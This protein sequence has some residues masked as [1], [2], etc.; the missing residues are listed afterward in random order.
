MGVG[1]R[2]GGAELILPL[3]IGAAIGASRAETPQGYMERLYANYRDPSINPLAHPARYFAAPLVAAFK[4]DARLARG[5]VGYLDGDPIC[6]CQDPDGLR[7]SV[8]KVARPSAGKADVSVSIAFPGDEPRVARFSLVLTNA[9][10]R[11]ADVS[12]IDEPSLL[13][14]IEKSNGAQRSKH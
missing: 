8:T 12:S 1:N 6:Q 5:E 13:R 14:A 11:I 10:W 3:L 9:G 7:A 2:N 4:E